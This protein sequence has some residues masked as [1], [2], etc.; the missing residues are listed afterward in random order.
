MPPLPRGFV[1]DALL[2]A[3]L[4]I[5]QVIIAPLLAI[6]TVTPDFVLIGIFFIAAK[7]GRMAGAI[8]GFA[9]GIAIDLS[10]GEVAGLFALAKTLSGFGAGFLYDAEHPGDVVRTARFVT[11]TAML[12]LLHNTVA[13]LFYL[14][15]VNTSYFVLLLRHGFGGAIYSTVFTA[16][17][18][19][20]L[21]RIAHRIDA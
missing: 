10:I 7:R 11:I 18:V 20:I 4:V 9:A 1:S 3:A 15:V 12:A 5:L 17:A 8:V 21:S 14:R 19:L 16:S 6:S 13:L 2:L